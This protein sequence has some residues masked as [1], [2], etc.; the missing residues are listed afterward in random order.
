MGA[1]CTG[2]GALPVKPGSPTKP[3]PGYRIEVVDEAGGQ[4]P[5]GGIG[6]IVVRLPLPPGFTPT[7]WNNDK[8]FEEAYFTRFPAIT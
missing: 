2:L 8:R 4:V 1:N 6:S 7:L 5:P 3:V